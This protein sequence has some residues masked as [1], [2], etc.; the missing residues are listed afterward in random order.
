MTKLGGSWERKRSNVA[1]TKSKRK[2]EWR[3]TRG[4]SGRFMGHVKKARARRHVAPSICTRVALEERKH[5]SGWGA[6]LTVI[7]RSGGWL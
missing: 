1:K 2:L 4:S 6:R 7:G 3:K 5:T